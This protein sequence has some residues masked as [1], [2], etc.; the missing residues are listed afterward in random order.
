MYRLNAAFGKLAP[1]VLE[2]LEEQLDL[3]DSQST[4][5]DDD[6]FAV[7]IDADDTTKDYT[8]I[9]EALRDETSKDDVIETL[10]DA[11]ETVL[12][13]DKGQKNEQAALRALSQINSKI[14]GVDVSYAGAKTL[15]AMLK[16]IETI[17]NSL[18][19]IERAVAKRQEI[20]RANVRAED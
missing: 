12:E 20:G 3:I 17:R 13:L 7:D 16:Q 19:R 15:P 4:H 9:I 11:C 14:T 2:I 10:I 18:D 5:V 1:K 6:D 8:A